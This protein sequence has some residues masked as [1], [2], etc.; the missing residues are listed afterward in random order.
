MAVP[1]CR[2]MPSEAS[3]RSFLIRCGLLDRRHDDVG[4]VDPL[5]QVPQPLPPD[6][7]GDRDLAAHHQELQ[8]L[9]DVAV[10]RPAGRG[11]RHHGRVRDV[12][13]GQ[14][15][16]AAEQLEDVAP[17]PVVVAEPGTHALVAAASRPRRRGTGPGRPS[18]APARCARTACGPA[19]GPAGGAPGRTPSRGGSRRRGRRWAR[20]PRSG[21]S[22]AGSAAAP[23][24]AGRSAGVRRA[25]A[26]A[27][28]CAGPAPW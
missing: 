6:A 1:F 26:R 10:V 15:P 22:A 19:P 11:P 13:G 17:E 28:R 14:R 20:S 12:A 7:P 25:A 21:R 3:R 5:G 24:R 16:G 4:R 8:H 23:P 27:P 9:G 2:A 18:A